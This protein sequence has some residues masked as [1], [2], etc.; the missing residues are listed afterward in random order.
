MRLDPDSLIHYGSLAGSLIALQRF[1]EA[2]QTIQQAHARESD[3]NILHV[4]LYALAFL[5]SDSSAMEEQQKWFENR[6]D[7]ENFGLSLA[8]DTDAYSGHLNNARELT[9]WS[10]K[11]AIHA[12][13][14][15]SAAIWRE[16]AAL[17]EAAFG[18]LA[19][20]K[21]AAADGLKLALISRSVNVEAALAYAI[22][23]DTTRA[24]SM[25]QELNKRFPLDTQIQSLWLPAI[26]A[27]LALNQKNPTLGL[28]SLQAALPIELAN[29]P[30]ANNTS[31]LYHT[32][33]RGEAYL[34]TGQGSAAVGEFQKILD[35]SSIVWNCWTG[36]LAR[37]G[38]ARANALEAKTSQGADADAARTRSLAAYKDFLTLWRDADPDIPIL[39]QAKA[40][41]AK[42]Q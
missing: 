7:S 24:E 6:P 30:F 13:N 2:R 1:D 25:A 37:L 22:S 20:A 15:E 16:N 9:K 26:R 31:C 11:S 35:H 14:K 23:G 42:L 38:V 34:A 41:Y 40:E 3:D 27:Q 4:N 5:T 17:R 18:N 10:V 19:E 8:S 32:Y 28:N 33:I 29:I 39:K 21:Q 36:S 12:D